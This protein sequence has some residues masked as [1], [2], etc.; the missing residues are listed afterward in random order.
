MAQA[1]ERIS[2]R[3]QLRILVLICLFQPLAFGQSNLGS[4]NGQVVDGTGAVIPGAEIVVTQISTNTVH[5]IVSNAQGLFLVPS[6]L[7]SQYTMTISMPGFKAKTF[8][9]IDLYAAQN[10]AMGKIALELGAGPNTVIDVTAEAVQIATSNAVRDST[11]QAGQV[12][13]MPLQGRNWVTLLK[14][15]P[16]ST[17]T[18]TQGIVGR[19]AGYDGMADFRV[20]GKSGNTTQMNLDGGSNVDHG[21]DGKTTVSPALESIQ[22]VSVIT[23]NFQA[24]YGSKSGVIVNVVTKSGT[25]KWHATLYEYLRNEALNANDS[26]NNFQHIARPRYRYNYFGGN[27]GGPILKDKLFFFFNHES[28]KQDS[29]NVTTLSRVPTA[30]ERVGD[31]SETLRADGS[32]PVIYYPG[33]QAAGAPVAIPNNIIPESMVSPLSKKLAALYPLP[34][35]PNNLT[36]NYANENPY[37]DRR[38]LN[39]GRVDWN[40]RPGTRAY[41]RYTYDYQTRRTNSAMPWN[42]GGWDRPDKALTLNL[43]HSVTARLFT[44]VLFNWQK[45]DVQNFVFN[46][47]PDEID[48]NKVGLSDL[49]LVFKTTAAGNNL[50]PAISGT[51]F[52]DYNFNRIPWE[53]IA[54]EWQLSNNW[55]LVRGTHVF[56]GGWQIIHNSKDERSN[57]TTKGSYNFAV[58]TSSPYDTGYNQA[59][60]MVGAVSQFQQVD[61]ESHRYSKYQDFHF[62]IQ[63]TWKIKPT[64]TLD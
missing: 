9:K 47:N 21:T 40:I 2:M 43:S 30:K 42:P 52:Y 55:T 28:L 31:F 17:P 12:D 41:G 22:E 19:E 60:F 25:N 15:I 37:K 50:L 23:N 56:K 6:L 32:K 49:P 39:V 33:T 63:D 29:P 46:E 34:N 45:D 62:F 11:I 3:N 53:A 20:N 16:G 1:K 10:L 61:N 26:S 59:N 18:T 38:W 8:E 51:G 36:N 64:L 5:K 54:P 4:I 57:D 58:S 44:E 13:Q 27:L 24:E 14:I 7:A 48:R 35:F